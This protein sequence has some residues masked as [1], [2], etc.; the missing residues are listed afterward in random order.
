MA[1]SCKEC[2]VEGGRFSI[3]KGE[4]YCPH[5]SPRETRVDNALLHASANNPYV[6]MTLADKMRIT[7]RKK[8]PDG[9]WRASKR[10]RGSD[11]Y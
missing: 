3:I 10:W 7:T 6:K 11:G 1:L 5:C 4:A 8:G 2:K 9:V